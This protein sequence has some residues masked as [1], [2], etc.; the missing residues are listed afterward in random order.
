LVNIANG[1]FV[2]SLQDFIVSHPQYKQDLKN[3]KDLENYH[4]LFVPKN[5]QLDSFVDLK[6]FICENRL[7]KNIIIILEKHA[8]LKLCA[9]ESFTPLR[10][11]LHESSSLYCFLSLFGS[12][13]FENELHLFLLGRNAKAIV[14]GVYVADNM[15]SMSLKTYQ[16]HM[17]QDASSEVVINGVALENACVSYRGNIFVA[18]KASRTKALQ[19]NKNIILGKRALVD[20]RPNM[21]ILNNNVQCKHGCAVGVLDENQLFYLQTRGLD[22]NKAKRLIVKGLFDNL[23]HDLGDLKQEKCKIRQLMVLL[24]G[25]L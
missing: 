19:G 14:R 8:A 20:S 15:Q 17:A 21:E 3:I 16:V 5:V 2:C 6:N 9:D 22:L 12:D 11:Y 24:D 4:V 18:Q 13:S 25:A 1:V 23:M 7:P 10:F